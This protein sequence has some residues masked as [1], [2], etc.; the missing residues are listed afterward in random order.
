[1]FNKKKKY[2]KAEEKRPFLA[3]IKIQLH[4]YNK[5]DVANTSTAIQTNS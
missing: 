4:L 5:C 1:M 3:Y 2:L